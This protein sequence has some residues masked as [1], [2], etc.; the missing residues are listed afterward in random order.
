MHEDTKVC[1]SEVIVSRLKSDMH[2]WLLL[3]IRMLALGPCELVWK[4]TGGQNTYSLEVSMDYL[5]AVHIDQPPNDT[6]KLQ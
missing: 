2:A 4:V 5:L 1:G 6:Y 3:L